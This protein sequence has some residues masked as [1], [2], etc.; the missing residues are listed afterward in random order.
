MM[1]AIVAESALRSLLLGGAVW[2]GLHLLRVRN[3]HVQ[4]TS[5][6]LVLLASLSMPL[7]MHWTTVTIALHPSPVPVSVPDN[8]WPAQISLPEL[9]QSRRLRISAPRAQ[10]AP[11][12]SHPSIGGPS[13]RQSTQLSQRCC[14]CGWRSVST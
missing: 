5:W 1:L 8:L 12:M 10:L 3:P 13:R 14:C 6:V 11:N 2:I 7:L 4:M 9:S